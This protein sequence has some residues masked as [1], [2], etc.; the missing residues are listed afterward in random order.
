VTPGRD[1]AARCLWITPCP[2]PH[3]ASHCVRYNQPSTT[4]VA[5]K[6]LMESCT[7][8]TCTREHAPASHAVCAA[9]LP[10][11]RHPP[12]RCPLRDP[13][14]NQPW[15]TARSLNM[16]GSKKLSR[17]Q[18]S[19]RLFCSGVPADG[20]HPGKPITPQQSPPNT[21]MSQTSSTPHQ[22]PPQASMPEGPPSLQP[23]AAHMLRQ[24]TSQQQLVVRL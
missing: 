15:K 20:T 21:R 12:L 10:G 6:T 8:H 18:S 14:S 4:G 22:Q 7:M 17:L 2:I 9:P 11:C 16:S 13:K 19:P 3:Q 24:P 5:V 23:P 1:L